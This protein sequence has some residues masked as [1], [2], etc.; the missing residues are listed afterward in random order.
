M[1]VM[2]MSIHGN[3]NVGMYGYCT[4]KYLLLGPEVPAQYHGEL[5]EIFKLKIEKLTI[6]GTSLLGVFLAGNKH[7]LL[8]PNIAYDYEI[9][10]L[11]KL[12][13]NFKVIDS[14]LTCFGNNVLVNDHFCLLNPEFSDKEEELLASLLKV[15]AMR[16]TIAGV[17]TVASICLMNK[18]GLLLHYEASKEELKLVGQKFKTQ[19][20]HGS[21]N[22][23]N[24]YVRSGILLNDHGFIIG[25]LSGG[26]EIVHA[27]GVFGFTKY[28]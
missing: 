23:G 10:R 3:P 14:R 22:L 26:P 28:R 16:K 12:K 5:E 25:E 13:L 27:E 11:E 7:C 20:E 18:K 1:H 15:P 24:P 9:A 2:K 4:E 19:A 17:H 21:V 6:A 8:V